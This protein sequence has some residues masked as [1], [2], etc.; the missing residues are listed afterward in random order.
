[1]AAIGPDFISLQVR[2][3]ERSAEF[4][5]NQLGLT[6]SKSG[7]PHAVVF[8][9]QPVFFAVRE[10]LP[11]VDLEAMPHPGEGIA[12]WLRATDA[13]GLHDSL[14]ASGTPITSAPFDGPF[15]RTFTFADP[16]RYRITIHDGA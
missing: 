11:G 4:Y 8:A 1:M 9:T 16:D 3:I 5:E 14:S 13:Q 12:P 2:D 6:R 10:P 15:G 7:P